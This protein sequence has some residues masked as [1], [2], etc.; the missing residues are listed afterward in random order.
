MTENITS[1]A[2]QLNKFVERIER[3]EEERRELGAD[4]REVYAEAKGAGFDV[5]VLR[6][7]IRLRK[8]DPVDRQETEFLRDEYKKLS[9]AY[10]V[11]EQYSLSTEALAE[12]LENVYDELDSSYIIN[13]T[14]ETDDDFV[15]PSST[16]FTLNIIKQRNTSIVY[17]II[18]DTEGSVEINITV[19]DAVYKSPIDN[20]QLII[21]G[22][23]TGTVT[24]GIVYKNTELTEGET[25]FNVKFEET[26]DYKE[27]ELDITLTVQKDLQNRGAKNVLE[28]LYLS[29][30][31]STQ[32]V[33]KCINNIFD[34]TDVYLDSSNLGMLQFR[35][36]TDFSSI[37]EN[38]Q[39]AFEKLKDFAVLDDQG[40]GL[41]SVLGMITAIVALEKPIILLDEPEAFLHPPQALQLG[42]IIS[43]LVKDSQQI[44]VATHSADFLRGLLGE[45][46][47]AV[48]IHLDR[49]KDNITEARVLDSAALSQV[50]TDPL[51]SSS[52]VLEG[53]FYKGVVATEADSDTAFY[54][55]LFQKVGASDEIHFLQTSGKQ[56]LKKIISPYQKLGIKFAIIADADVI[57]ER[58]DVK[59]LLDLTSD[60]TTKEQILE[61]R[62]EV[63]KYFQ[64]Q[65][66]Y[67]RLLALQTALH[68]LISAE[69]PSETSSED[70]D[71]ALADYRAK[72]GKLREESDDLSKLKAFGRECFPAEEQ[73]RFDKL[74]NLCSNIGLFIVWVG[75]L[76]SWLVDYGIE[77]TS[78]KPKWIAEALTK[79]YESEPDNDKAIW[80]FVYSLR[81]FLIS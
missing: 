21:T 3:L 27:S 72:L 67:D 36:G 14:Y 74:C 8:M 32:S 42:K 51:I 81:D 66:K 46:Q 64:T 25:V 69:L 43:N 79:I 1:D 77:R 78:N 22:D 11:G 17:D 70:I 39:A 5:K 63:I 54:Q 16:E 31:N 7:I 6:Q 15:S 65:S 23:V 75:E 58:N 35:V 68:K 26:E 30:V 80:K 9:T 61:E 2:G 44:F 33:R 53:M 50:I 52:R 55:R 24:S 62:D 59:A 49:P 56:A 48:I 10:N 20:V 73:Q 47:D 13:A 45:T 57:R 34:N 18:N 19:M 28:A 29:G 4:V 38:P 41:R 40:D 12:L 37:P 76:E 60:E 71:K